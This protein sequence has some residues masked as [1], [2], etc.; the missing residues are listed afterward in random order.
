M[1]RFALLIACTVAVFI[2]AAFVLPGIFVI[3]FFWYESNRPSCNED[4][5][6]VA[7]ARS[8]SQERLARLYRD[9]EGSTWNTEAPVPKEFADLKVARIRPSEGNIMVHGC[10]DHYVYLTFEGVGVEKKFA[11]KRQIILSWGERPPQAGEQV[12]WTDVEKL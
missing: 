12:L 2:V 11:R 3:P 1:K 7:Y 5:P 8:L 9:M 6:V 4:S 10:F